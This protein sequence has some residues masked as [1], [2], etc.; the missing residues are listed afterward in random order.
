MATPTRSLPAARPDRLRHV[1]MSAAAM[2]A[3]SL[4]LTGCISYTVGQGADTAPR[5]EQ[6]FSTSINVVPGTL[7]GGDSVLT[8][9]TRRPSVDSEMRFGIDDRSD[10][11]VRIAT[12]SGFMLT[13]KRQ[14]GRP[15]VSPTQPENRMRSAF[16]LGTGILNAGEHAGFEGTLI[17]SGPWTAAGQLYGAARIIQV[18]PITSSARKDEPSVGFAIGHLFGTKTSSI[19]AEMGVY[20]D[21]STL[22]LNSNRILVIPSLVFRPRTGSIFGGVF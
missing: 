15:D 3:A 21:R 7:R 5:G 14:L 13:Y 10:I 4:L 16:M 20:Y 12:Y 6:V 2:A 9:S 19:G 8:P 22:G 11:G 17:T 18:L 1:A